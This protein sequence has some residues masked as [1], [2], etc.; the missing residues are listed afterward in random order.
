[1]PAAPHKSRLRPGAE[2]CQAASGL[3]MRSSG[4]ADQLGQAVR[5]GRGL[6][7]RGSR[8]PRTLTA[9]RLIVRCD[10][11]GHIRHRL[12]RDRRRAAG[13]RAAA[14]LGDALAEAAEE[15]RAAAGS[16][17]CCGRRTTLLGAATAPLADAIRDAP[18]QARPAA[19]L[20][21]TGAARGR[22]VHDVI[23]RRGGWH[24]RPP[25]RARRRTHERQTDEQRPSGEL[26]H[27]LDLMF[28]G[29][30][31]HVSLPP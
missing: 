30:A 15:A 23:L 25:T 24:R 7:V 6:R 19:G 11:V 16:G 21:T 20:R 31:I 22:A 9:G 17:A 12:T 2:N 3:F 28:K 8:D 27:A 14:A 5:G 26:L 1:M 10:R 18:E 29:D 13:G 4:H